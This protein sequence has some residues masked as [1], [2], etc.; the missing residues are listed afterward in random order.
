LLVATFLLS[1]CH[2][3]VAHTPEPDRTVILEPAAA[4]TGASL[5]QTASEDLPATP[6]VAAIQVNPIPS[7]Q[8]GL[9]ATV[10]TQ[11]ERSDIVHTVT[12][13]PLL[14]LQEEPDPQPA[15]N[16]LPDS[17]VVYSPTAVDFD[18]VE[19]IAHAGGYLSDYRQYLRSTGWTDAADILLRVSR[20]SSIN[21]RLLLALVEYQTGCVRGQPSPS[22]D[23][24][25]LMGEPDYHHKGFYRQLSWA[26]SQLSAGYYG[27]REGRLGAIPLSDGTI[28]SPDPGLNAGSVALQYYLAQV[29]D[30]ANWQRAT[31]PNQGLVALY[32]EMFPETLQHSREI[33]GALLF[34][35][36][37]WTTHGGSNPYA[38]G[39]TRGKRT[40][41]ASPYGT[42]ASYIMRTTADP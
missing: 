40:V 29:L 39:L 10:R 36:S 21:P 3:M 38:G 4:F 11:W 27:W 18:P 23:M 34:V 15:A 16:L 6:P 2:P 32:Y 24:D 28:I 37:G 17:E 26:A 42:S 9:L 31:A 35:F 25:T 14:A 41:I 22:P 13:L 1:A 8:E 7:P 19:Y 30:Y 20:E 33:E 5:Q 12:P